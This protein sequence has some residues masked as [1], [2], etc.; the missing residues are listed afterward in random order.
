MVGISTK[1]F[2]IADCPDPTW[3]K[4]KRPDFY[5]ACGTEMKTV[6]FQFTQC[7]ECQV[8]VFTLPVTKTENQSFAGLMEQLWFNFWKTHYTKYLKVYTN[9]VHLFG[10]LEHVLGGLRPPPTKYAWWRPYWAQRERIH[11]GW[12]DCPSQ[13]TLHTHKH[14]HTHL[15]GN[16]A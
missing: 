13:G 12:D 11:T 3:I 16:L 1:V 15:M 14:T 4:S 9:D 7:T 2:T 8:Y 6:A 5:R 10:G